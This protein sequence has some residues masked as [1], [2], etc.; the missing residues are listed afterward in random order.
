M[1]SFSLTAA[2]LALSSPVNADGMVEHQTNAALSAFY[3]LCLNK[4][5]DAN[6]VSELSERLSWEQI[7]EE[8]MWA[9]IPRTEAEYEFF[10]GYILLSPDDPPV[11]MLAFAGLSIQETEPVHHCALFFRD[12]LASEFTTAFVEDTSA[13][14]V[15]DDGPIGAVTRFYQVPDFPKSL[16]LL[17]SEKRNERGLLANFLFKKS[18]EES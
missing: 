18:L 3:G 8:E 1:K 13:R 10:D 2:F 9:F 16:V 15:S 17:E 5:F 11:P 7:S 4:E 6:A 14:L 12:V